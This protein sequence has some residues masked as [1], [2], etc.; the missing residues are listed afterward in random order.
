MKIQTELKAGAA[1]YM[2]KPGDSLSTIA[3]DFYGFPT[4]YPK[5]YYSNLKRIGPN[6]NV[7]SVGT[8]L[9]IPD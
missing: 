2:V 1:C 4:E 5:I 9:Y 8:R 3:R 7:V 6:P